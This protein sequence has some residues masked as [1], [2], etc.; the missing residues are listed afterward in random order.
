MEILIWQP[1]E[2]NSAKS[3]VNLEDLKLQVGLE[4]LANTLILTCWDLEH[5]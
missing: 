1:Q 3:H 4:S 5:S 2:M